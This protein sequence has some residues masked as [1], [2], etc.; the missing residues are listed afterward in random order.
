MSDYTAY[1][2]GASSG[3]PGDAGVGLVI[4]KDGQE[5]LRESK[6]IGKETNNV[7]EYSALILLLDIAKKHKIS[8]IKVF[9]DSELMVKQLKGEYKI[10]NEGL[11]K[12]VDRVIKAKKYVKFFLEHTPREKNS[13]ADKLAKAASKR[14]TAA[15]EKM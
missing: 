12:L 13:E 6:Y 4:Y 1:I 9:S 2:D 15:R 11:K 14:G 3:N 7:A 8:R 5:V 10:K